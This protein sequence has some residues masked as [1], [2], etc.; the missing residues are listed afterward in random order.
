MRAVRLSSSTPV[1]R[2]PGVSAS[3]IS[4][5]KCP[6]PIDGSRTCATGLNT[7][8]CKSLPHPGNHYEAR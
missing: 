5:K 3:G 2:L 8:P 6:T 4:P 1:L 7:E